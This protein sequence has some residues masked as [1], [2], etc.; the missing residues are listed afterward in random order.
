MNVSEEEKS[1]ERIGGYIESLSSY[2]FKRNNRLVAIGGGV[3]Q[4]IT[5]F[6]A[7]IF[8]RGVKWIYIPT[9]L[10]AQADSCIGSKSSINFGGIKNQ[11]GSYYPPSE[12]FSD[13]TFLLTL[14]SEAIRSGVGEMAHYFILDSEKSFSFLEDNIADMLALGPSTPLA[15][16]ESLRIKKSFIEDDEFDLGQRQLLNYGHSFAHAIEGFTNYKIP[17]GVAVS[18][19]IILANYLAVSRGRMN[20]WVA[21]RIRN[22]LSK[23]WADPLPANITAK[24]LIELLRKDK[25]NQGTKLRLILAA[26]FGDVFFDD[27][28]VEPGLILLLDEVL[29]SLKG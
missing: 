6:V 19:G 8:F 17:H 7:Q 15:I 18:F 25:K 24:G 3:V 29:E 13:S 5:S 9:T 11:L 16:R 2:D 22:T 23:L 10:L 1:F 26:D 28:D 4:D 14:E 20:E 21:N 12:I 27:V